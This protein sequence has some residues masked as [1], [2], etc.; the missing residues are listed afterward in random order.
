MQGRAAAKTLQHVAVPLA[1]NVKE[2]VVVGAGPAGAL[3]AL[4]LAERGVHVKV[5]ERS[6]RDP[7]TG[8]L[9]EQFVNAWNITLTARAFGALED[10]GIE[11]DGCLENAGVRLQGRG[12]GSPSGRWSVITCAWPTLNLPAWAVAEVLIKQAIARY[13]AVTEVGEGA[14]TR[15]P[16]PRLPCPLPMSHI[17]MAHQ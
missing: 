14:A 1:G 7:S 16:T 11:M 2:A 10:A 3:L 17:L 15:R 4:R 8:W 13:P 6:P 12:V 9:P 5:F